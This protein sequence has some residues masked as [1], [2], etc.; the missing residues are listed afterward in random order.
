MI[1]IVEPGVAWKSFLDWCMFS[2]QR[3]CPSKLQGEESQRSELRQ[4]GEG[5]KVDT[6]GDGDGE[7]FLRTL[8]GSGNEGARGKQGDMARLPQLFV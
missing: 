3:R 7:G 8:W 6:G 5:R 2:M 4:H 1:F